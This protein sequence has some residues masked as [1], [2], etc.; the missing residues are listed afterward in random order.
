MDQ[1]WT[2]NCTTR[3]V[4]SC[5]GNVHHGIDPNSSQCPAQN[6]FLCTADKLKCCQHVGTLNSAGSAFST[7]HS[8]FIQAIGSV[9]LSSSFKNNTRAGLGRILAVACA[10]VSGVYL[11]AILTE[12]F[13][14]GDCWI[15]ML[16]P[17]LVQ[18]HFNSCRS[19]A[20]SHPPAPQGA[21]LHWVESTW[22]F[23]CLH[24]SNFLDQLFFPL[25]VWI[26]CIKAQRFTV[27]PGSRHFRI[28]ILWRTVFTFLYWKIV[29]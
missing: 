24:I 7:V 29:L 26:Q 17:L 28:V 1:I 21:A 12:S 27:G 20:A 6:V 19:S 22:H 10:L 2:E 11:A 14:C 5:Y 3:I 13:C 16:T 8:T 18:C 4:D 23:H 15:Q 9:V 25:Q